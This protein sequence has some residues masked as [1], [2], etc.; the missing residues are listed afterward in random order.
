MIIRPV[1]PTVAPLAELLPRDIDP[2]LGLMLAGFFV[3]IFGHMIRARWLVVIGVAMIVLSTL[4]FPLTR[5][6]TEETPP[7]PRQGLEQLP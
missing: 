4:V 3:S 7:P 2:Y 1:S 5:V 6:I